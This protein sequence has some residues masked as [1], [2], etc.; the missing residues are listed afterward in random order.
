MATIQ[1]GVTDK[2]FVR[3]PIKDILSNLNNKFIA[4]FG[5]NFDVS[6]ESPDGQIIGIVADEID[7]C[8]SQAQAVYN[9]Y[10]PGAVS[11]IGL[12]NIC[13]LTN[14]RRYV[15]RPT[16]VTVVCSG[17]SGTTVPAGSRVSDGSM[18][19]RLTEA[20]SIPG[21]ATA[22]AEMSGEYYVA[23]GKVT[24]ILTPVAGWTGVT[25]PNI[26]QT[27][28]DY[29][30]DPSLRVRRDKTTAL[31]SSS[32]IESIYAS[33]SELGLD[34][35]RIR[36]NDT[37]QAING[38][39]AGT[40]FIVVDGGTENDIA[41]RIYNYKTCGVPTHGNISKTIRDSKGNPH[42]VKFSRSAPQS[43]F[44]A[45]KFKRTSDS[46]QSSNDAAYSLQQA[47]INYLNDLSPG[48]SV[49]WSSLF[50]PLMSSVES[51]E[52][53]SLFIGI[54][55]NP[56][57]TNTIPLDIDRRAFGAEANIKFTEQV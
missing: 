50:A 47:A 12:D 36:D 22:V 39:P 45:G 28:V 49:V 15:D 37:T 4:E 41:R 29:E 17:T 48:E 38:Q 7:Q 8:W 27:G 11:G 51:I 55:A 10:R 33:L 52:I 46:K 26:G 34:Y 2:G 13:E 21:D 31:G 40:V 24:K 54:A 32:M 30:P 6:P 25:N 42:V 56:T 14:V 16:Q 9:A 57:T 53:V 18:N 1:Y 19:F 23:A 44:I 43:I 3:K 35:I 5:D 20:V